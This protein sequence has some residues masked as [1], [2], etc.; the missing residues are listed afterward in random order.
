MKYKSKIL[1]VLFSLMLLIGIMLPLLIA[2]DPGHD[3]RI[4]NST[5]ETL[6]IYFDVG[7]TGYFVTLGNLEPG[8]HIYASFAMMDGYCQIDA[9]N[10]EGELIF[11]REYDWWEL[12]D[13][14]DWTVVITP[15]IIKVYEP[16]EYA[17]GDEYI[18]FTAEGAVPSFSFEYPSDYNLLSYQ[19]MPQ[20]PSTSVLLSDVDYYQEHIVNGEIIKGDIIGC[21][22]EAEWD[23]KHMQIFVYRANESGAETEVERKIDAYR[24]WVTRGWSEDFRLLEKNRVVVAGLEGWEIVISYI[25]L[26]PVFVDG[27]C[28][29]TRAVAVVNRFLFF[30][31]QDTIWEIR[32]YSDAGNADQ[33]RLD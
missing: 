4:E 19:P 16:I 1:L 18:T 10:A 22:P 32:L 2:C 17:Y 25:D 28:P 27:P 30:D 26:P 29:R 24:Q 15:P 11:S 5:E 23:Y 9:R 7:P 3:I 31:Y 13:E 8:E 6:T 33:A 14:M 20:Y 12:R 21:P